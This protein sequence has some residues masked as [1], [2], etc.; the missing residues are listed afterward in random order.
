MARTNGTAAADGSGGAARI[1]VAVIYPSGRATELVGLGGGRPTAQLSVLVPD[2]PSTGSWQMLRERGPASQ[3]AV[4]LASH[5]PVPPRRGGERSMWTEGRHYALKLGSELL[6]DLPLIS[7]CGA[8]DPLLAG[9]A[10][11]G[12]RRSGAAHPGGGPSGLH[13]LGGNA[14]RRAHHGAEGAEECGGG[15][16]TTTTKCKSKLVEP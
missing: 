8:R 13:L 12:A 15:C 4:W 16:R 3:V 10:R 6:R 1:V 14:R 9:D 5:D 7:E 11:E 2:K